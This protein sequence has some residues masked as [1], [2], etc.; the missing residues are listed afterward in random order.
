MLTMTKAD[1][2][3][4]CGVSQARVSQWITEGKIGPECLVGEGRSARVNVELAKQQVGL[5]RDP[6]QS[7]GNGIG[8]RLFDQPT[9]AQPPRPDFPRNERD[10]VAQRIQEERLEAEQRKNRIAARDELVE[11][12]KL[13]PAVE[14]RSQLI[15]VAKQVDEENGAMLADFAAAIASKF[16]LPSRDVLHLLRGVR[17]E[18]KAAAAERL[19]RLGEEVPETVEVVL[20]VED[21]A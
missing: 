18:K 12:G 16:G 3:R 19:R 20:E 13:V 2:A 11:Q 1:F 8:T 10:D 15:R 7:L 6:G 9:P 4:E 5:R 14:V 17:N 21:G